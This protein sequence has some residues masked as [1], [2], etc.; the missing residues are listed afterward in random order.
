MLDFEKLKIKMMEATGFTISSHRLDFYGLC[1]D[2]QK[3]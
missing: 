2:C 1:P 3:K